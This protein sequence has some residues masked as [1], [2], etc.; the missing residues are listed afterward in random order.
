L[1]SPET[2]ETAL[3]TVALFM[4]AQQR[5]EVATKLRGLCDDMIDRA[6]AELD[7]GGGGAAHVSTGGPRKP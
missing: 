1:L 6:Q 7:E 3:R 4:P 5:L 2:L